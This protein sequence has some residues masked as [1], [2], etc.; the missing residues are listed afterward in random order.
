MRI[1]LVPGGAQPFVQVCIVSV[2]LLGVPGEASDSLAFSN[3]VPLEEDEMAGVSGTG[4][5]FAFDDFRFQM[6]PTSYFEQIGAPPQGGTT[7]RR[8][9]YRWIGTTISSAADIS[10][11]LFHFSDY[12]RGDHGAQYTGSCTIS[13]S[14][15]DC[16]IARGPVA[17]YADLNNPFLLR[18]REYEAVG[19]DADKDADPDLYWS[20]GEGNT[21]AEL[22]GPTRSSPFRWAFWG[23]VEVTDN[24]GTPV[25]N[26]TLQNQEI[27]IGAPVSRFRPGGGDG[28]GN[29]AGPVFRLYRNQTDHSLGMIYHHRLSGDFRFSVAQSSSDNGYGVPTFAPEEGMYFIDVNTY[30][31]MGQMHYQSMILDGTSSRDGNFSVTLSRLPDSEAVYHDFYGLNGNPASFDYGYQRSGRPD[32]YYETHGYVLWGDKFPDRGGVS[33]VRYAGVDPDGATRVINSAN[34]PASTCAS[35]PRGSN[36][37]TTCQAWSGETVGN[38]VTGAASRETVLE[39]GGM[40]FVSRDPSSTWR[41]VNNQSQ[42]ANNNLQMLR[43][44][45][46]G[47]QTELQRDPAYNN[48]NPTLEVN[49]INLGSSRAEG[50]TIQHL[51]ITTLGAAN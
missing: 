12:G 33:Q 35:V 6:A 26:G 11:E 36:A 34:F 5:A 1:N 7:F 47:S 48:Y 25:P 2:V 13:L 44:T 37:G 22:I 50:M 30:L 8:G 40:I 16:P 3:M 49:A 18:V 20:P 39:Q 19:R 46:N 14:S 24:A 17:G 15:L 23:E 42:A 43:A 32:R 41:V 10:G 28:A 21:V 31:P 27:I 45:W 4:L 38:V 29:I 51:K 9:N